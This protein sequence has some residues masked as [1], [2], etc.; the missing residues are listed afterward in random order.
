VLV[1]VAADSGAHAPD[2]AGLHAEP[3]AAM[4]TFGAYAHFLTR[5]GQL[6]ALQA[7]SAVRLIDAAGASHACGPLPRR[8][9]ASL[10]TESGSRSSSRANDAELG[11]SASPGVRPVAPAPHGARA[12]EP[13]LLEAIAEDLEV[14]RLLD[15]TIGLLVAAGCEDLLCVEAAHEQ[16]ADAG[17]DLPQGAQHLGTVHV[18]HGEVEQD[19]IDGHR[20]A[21]EHGDGLLTAFGDAH[22]TAH[23]AQ[24]DRGRVSHRLVIVDHEHDPA[25]GVGLRRERW[26]G[27]PGRDVTFVSGS[28]T[29]QV[30]PSRAR[31]RCAVRRRAHARC[32]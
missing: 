7:S 4:P 5:Q 17:T 26:L 25:S 11:L 19:G 20:F 32:P 21:L 24:H 8:P 29:R 3:D 31:C 22:A 6:A 9:F 28:Q 2:R 1:A 14:E 23:L 15:E 30:V 12:V 13:Q 27:K 10:T 18:R 16:H